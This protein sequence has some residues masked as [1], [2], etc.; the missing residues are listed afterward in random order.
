MS[1]LFHW[2]VLSVS[3]R[4]VIDYYFSGPDVLSPK[5]VDIHVVEVFSLLDLSIIRLSM[6]FFINKLPSF[7]QYNANVSKNIF[8]AGFD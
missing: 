7:N 5:S 4:V 3:T 8:S 1:R 6:Q 2:R